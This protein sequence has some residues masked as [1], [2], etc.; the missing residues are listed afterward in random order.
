MSVVSEWVSE[1]SRSVVSDSL[2][3]H[4]APPSMGFSRQEYWSGL[5]F[6]SPGDL[7]QP[8]IEP[9]SPT[10]QADAAMS[11]VRKVKN[12]TGII[13]IGRYEHIPGNLLHRHDLIGLPNILTRKW[14]GWEW[15]HP[16]GQ[17]P[18]L[19]LPSAGMRGWNT[20]IQGTNYHVLCFLSTCGWTSLPFSAWGP[21]NSPSNLSEMLGTESPA[22]DIL[23]QL[24]VCFSTTV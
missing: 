21:Y 13:Y 12:L 20:F 7:P 9:R 6:P 2:R 11:V 8:G 19:S 3:P 24:L 14:G 18:Y 22:S 1:W 17:K 23:R 15:L 5:P 10:L 16:L 4:Q